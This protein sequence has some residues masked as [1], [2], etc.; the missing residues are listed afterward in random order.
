MHRAGHHITGMIS[1]AVVAGI[2][3]NHLG[4]P[5]YVASV[6][7]PAGWYGGVF[8]DAIEKIGKFYWIEHR[9]VTHWVPLWIG[10]L[11]GIFLV[12]WN[13][14]PWGDL[15]FIGSLGFVVGGLTHLLFD[16]PNPTG[17]PI[18]TPF[19]RHSLNL[20]NSGRLDVVIVTLW[21]AGAYHLTTT[22][23]VGDAISYAL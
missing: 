16:W 15:C 3:H 23:W 12:D 14:L 20:W 9:T 17:I 11:V 22:A 10:L 21:A 19:H 1:G 4:F 18:L 5:L 13:A 7:V 6:A 2:A 8:P